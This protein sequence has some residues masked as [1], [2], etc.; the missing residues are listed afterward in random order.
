MGEEDDYFPGPDIMQRLRE[1]VKRQISPRPASPYP[2]L[3][4]AVG[5]LRKQYPRELS[6]ANI[7]P[8]DWSRE[9]ANSNVLGETNNETN[10]IEMNPSMLALF[11][12]M[13]TTRTLAHELTHVK[14]NNEIE[15]PFFRRKLNGYEQ[16]LPYQQRPSEK[17]A[18][19]AGDDYIHSL[20]PTEVQRQERFAQNIPATFWNGL[21]K[22]IKKR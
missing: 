6:A 22:T 16:M 10:N 5:A 17:E 1:N 2:T 18:F 13:D 11:P 21:P 15:D 3:D 8:M 9:E 12:Q 7:K 20:S 4:R 14:Q 19:A